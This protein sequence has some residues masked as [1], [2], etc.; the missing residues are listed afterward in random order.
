MADKT[1]KVPTSVLINGG[2]AIQQTRGARAVREAVLGQRDALVEKLQKIQSGDSEEFTEIENMM[3]TACMRNYAGKHR[4]KFIDDQ[5][6]NN[7][8]LKKKYT[9]HMGSF[10]SRVRPEDAANK[11]KKD[12]FKSYTAPSVDNVEDCLAAIPK[13]SSVSTSAGHLAGR[14]LD[15]AML[16]IMIDCIREHLSK[17]EGTPVMQY[18]ILSDLGLGGSVTSRIE[19]IVADEDYKD[20]YHQAVANLRRAATAEL[21]RDPDADE[22]D[23]EGNAKTAPTEDE[24]KRFCR[25]NV[26]ARF[27]SAVDCL[28]HEAY[29]YIGQSVAMSCALKG[30]FTVKEEDVILPLRAVLLSYGITPSQL[31]GIETV[32]REEYETAEQA[33]KDAKAQNA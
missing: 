16:D 29:Q 30:K 25:L 9:E 23:D 28:I 13:H 31:V 4:K 33:K 8:A 15:S 19:D 20:H 24:K 5:L 11:V 6:E 3:L 17:K 32:A 14:M 22:L 10:G 26:S 2:T 21:C 27:R 7:S 12:F 1:Y 18:T